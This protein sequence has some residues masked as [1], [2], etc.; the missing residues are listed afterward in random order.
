MTLKFYQETTKW[1][2][3]TSNHT[4]LLS[5][6]RSKMLAYV[7][8]G[9]RAVFK[10]K[11]PLRIDTRGRTFQVTEEDFGYTAEAVVNTNPQWQV[12]G[13]RGDVYTVEQTETGLTCTCSGFRFRGAC[14]HI[15]EVQA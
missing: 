6:D 8:A 9:T 10:F 7:P 13:S 3:A 11:N 4:Y 15:K 14:R 2:G 12:Q 1:A 5:K